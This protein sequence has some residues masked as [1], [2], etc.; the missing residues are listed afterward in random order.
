[1]AFFGA[2]AADSS[3]FRGKVQI[4]DDEVAAASASVTTHKDRQSRRRPDGIDADAVGGGGDDNDD[5][6]RVVAPSSARNIQRTKEV[7]HEARR[8]STDSS[9]TRKLIKGWWSSG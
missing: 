9:S 4:W 2:R 7:A 5:E 8:S 3:N 6:W 1:M